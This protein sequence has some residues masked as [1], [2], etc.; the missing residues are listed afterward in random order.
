MTQY[1]FSD[2]D[3][4]YG[5][6]V[7][8]KKSDGDFRCYQCIDFSFYER[9]VTEGDA[10]ERC[11]YCAGFVFIAPQVI[12]QMEAPKPVRPVNLAKREV[13]RFDLLTIA[14]NLGRRVEE[15][16]Y[17]YDKA[18]QRIAELEAQLAERETVDL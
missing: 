1:V 12:A 5:K 11:T 3:R 17:A 14:Y 6:R 13:Q 9:E 10:E 2:A 16:S 7:G 8:V 15:V 18:R 4:E